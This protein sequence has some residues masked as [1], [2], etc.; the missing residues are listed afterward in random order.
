MAGKHAG[1]HG[2]R[3]RK[4]RAEVLAASDVCHI[5]GLPGS[6]TVDHYPVSRADAIARG[7]LD[8]LE[9]KANLRPAHLGCN[10][11]RGRGRKPK[12]LGR[13]SRQW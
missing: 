9:D 1:R 11:S 4:V 10:S 13:T 6:T 8:L 12:P 2:Y 7:R 5:C 3:W